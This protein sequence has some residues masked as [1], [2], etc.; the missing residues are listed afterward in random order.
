MMKK[1]RTVR[2][3]DSRAYTK[4]VEH[5]ITKEFKHGEVVVHPKF[6]LDTLKC[7]VLTATKRGF[8][9]YNLFG[10]TLKSDTTK[11]DISFTRNTNEMFFYKITRKT[12]LGSS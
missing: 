11:I 5:R 10:F 4:E 9:G 3:T 7:A 6:T 8:T 12:C 2:N 1:T